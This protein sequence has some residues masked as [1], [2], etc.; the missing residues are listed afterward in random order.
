MLFRAADVAALPS[1]LPVAGVLGV[2]E[3]EGLELGIQLPPPLEKSLMALFSFPLRDGV[4]VPGMV[5]PTPL[6]D[7]LPPYAGKVVVPVFF[8]VVVFAFLLAAVL[9]LA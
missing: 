7:V 1:P 6:A 4:V 5:L 9:M 8:A 3:R 2:T